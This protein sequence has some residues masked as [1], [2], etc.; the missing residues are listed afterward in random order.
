M[1]FLHESHDIEGSNRGA[2]EGLLRDTALGIIA[3]DPGMRLCW[4][5]ES[6]PGS[7][8]HPAVVTMIALE[9]GS[10]LE[11]IAT[12]RRDGDLADVEASVLRYAE[13]R[14]SRL[15]TELD[16]SPLRPSIAEIPVE[17]VDHDRHLF[18]E[19]FVRPRTGRHE[20]YA[21]MMRKIYMNMSADSLDTIVLWADFQPVIGGGEFREWICFNKVQNVDA[22][23]RLMWFG[24][25]P[26]NEAIKSWMTEG[27]QTR[28]TWS[29]RFLRTS[30][31][32]PL[33]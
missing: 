14:Q 11:R 7:L 31:W 33:T 23:A 32:S 6:T 9:D 25:K 4:Y 21:E 16:F 3:E 26:T 8:R 5:A 13:Q 27:L 22:M 17:P 29:N 2:L 24:H 19:D 10:A 1:L 28:D 30:R 18:I 12:R 20:A 15:V